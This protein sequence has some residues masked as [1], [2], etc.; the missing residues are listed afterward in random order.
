MELNF[1]P[2]YTMKN[3]FASFIASNV[4]HELNSTFEPSIVSECYAAL[5]G[6][7]KKELINLAALIEA[8]Q[9]EE[10]YEN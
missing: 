3:Q 7:S 6:F 4:S 2:Q 8:A 1:K 10:S 5:Q 9:T